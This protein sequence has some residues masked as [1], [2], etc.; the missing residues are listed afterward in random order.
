MAIAAARIDRSCDIRQVALRALML[1]N[2]DSAEAG[3]KLAS[4]TL[5]REG[6]KLLPVS[7]STWR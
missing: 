1:D 7:D 3:C 2:G 4:Y 5:S 6:L